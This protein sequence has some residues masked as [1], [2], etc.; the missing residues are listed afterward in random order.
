[1][2]INIENT[3]KLEGALK[4]V[5][6]K[7]T[8]RTID[9]DRILSVLKYVEKRLGIGKTALKGTKVHFTG[10]EKFAKAYRFTPESTHFEAEHNG[11]TWF[12][13]SITRDTCP[14]RQDA[15]DVALSDTAKDAVLKSL[16]RM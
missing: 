10:A 13:T 6:G 8:A 14:Q 4:E 7:A 5:Q 9:V 2:K 15:I 3:E 1:M 12:V 11:K 16:S